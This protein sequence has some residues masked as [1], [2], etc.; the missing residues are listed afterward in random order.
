M[1]IFHKNLKLTFKLSLLVILSVLISFAILGWYFDVFIQKNYLQNTQKRMEHG[2]HRLQS[3][4]KAINK[5]LKKEIAFF[6]TD[7]GMLASIDLI[8]NYQDKNNYNAVLLDEEKKLITSKLL[9]KVKFSLN[10]EIILYDANQELIAYVIKTDHGYYMNFIS[11]DKGKRVLYSKYEAEKSYTSSAFHENRL[12]NFKHIAYYQ[13]LPINK[14]TITYH[15]YKH[16]INIKSHQNI[17]GSLKDRVIAHIE[18]TYTLDDNYFLNLSKDLDMNIT[19]SLDKKYHKYASSLLQT[20]S[21][22]MIQQNSE[23]Y[24]GAM[25]IETQEG[26]VYIVSTL[27]KAL[28]ISKLNESRKNFFLILF[29]VIFVILILVRFLFTRELAQP[30]ERLM[31][32]IEKIEHGDYSR[33]EPLKSH[34]E[35]QSISENINKLSSTIL[36]R[37]SA[38]KVSQINLEYLSNHDALTNLPNRRFFSLRLEH[39]LHLAK[40]NKSKLA[41][42]FIDLDQFKEV[43]DSLGHDIGDQLLIKVSKRLTDSLRA[44]DTIARIGG[45]EFNIMLENLPKYSEIDWILQKLLDDFKNAF[46]CSGHDIKTSASIGVAIYPEDGE[47]SVTLIKNAD[48]AMYQSKHLGRNSYSYFAKNLS[49]HLKERLERINALKK[50]VPNCDKEF[51]L[52]YQPKIS[53]DTGKITSVEALIRWNSSEFGLVRPD[54]FI[55]LAEESNLIVPLGEWIL[56]QACTDFVTLQSEGYELDHISI[57]VSSVQLLHSDMKSTLAKTIKTTGIEASK[58]EIEITE[59]YTVTDE[60]ESLKTLQSFRDMNLK[61]A[62]DDFGTGYSSLSYLQKLPVTRL[63]IDKSF[64]DDLPHSQESVA[65]AKAIIAL[66][67]TFNLRITAEGVETKEQL[68]FLKHEQCDEIQGYYY[69]KP[70]R[71]EALK[72]FYKK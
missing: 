44:S 38:L 33:S 35:L 21:K 18:M 42:L 66:A 28:L 24:M 55:T 15:S 68:E 1:K 10:N 39:A 31:Q 37:E 19:V 3:N 27:E 34:D 61:L 67:K 63:K 22:L 40:R 47:D 32:Q 17:Y 30:L 11:Y 29:I 12:I 23:Y 8:N 54:Q 41:V 49:D 60:E 64:V 50:A 6:Q 48:L 71:L 25:S 70:L 65:I 57:N 16:N 5:E 58:I 52:L 9:E 51:F 14:T 45:D 46:T 72:E 69:S 59:S 13:N 7:E 56:H 26:T 4:I 53:V 62:I 36:S 43:N 20:H 2:F